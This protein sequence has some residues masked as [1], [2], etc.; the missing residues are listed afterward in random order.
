MI[1]EKFY[2]NYKNNKQKGRNKMF[3]N[4]S[5]K[6]FIS[7]LTLFAYNVIYSSYY[8]VLHN[9][10]AVN[11]LN[12]DYTSFTDYQNLRML[13]NYSWIIPIL[14]IVFMFMPEIKLIIN[15]IKNEMKKG[16]I[17]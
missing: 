9:S 15:K 5:I 16:E 2:N 4:V 1:K 13:W 12:N 10:V 8:P 7:G 6:L 3:K 11:Q 17:N 14:G